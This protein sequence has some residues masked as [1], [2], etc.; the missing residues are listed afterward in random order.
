MNG[1]LVYFIGHANILTQSS[2][3]FFMVALL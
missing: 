2:G 3:S 1:Q